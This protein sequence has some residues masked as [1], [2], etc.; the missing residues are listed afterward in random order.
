MTSHTSHLKISVNIKT[1]HENFTQKSNGIQ[2]MREWHVGQTCSGDFN[3]KF[4][5]GKFCMTSC[6]RHK[7]GVTDYYNSRPIYRPVRYTMG[8]ILSS[9]REHK[10]YFKYISQ[11]NCYWSDCMFFLLLS[12]G[13]QVSRFSHY[14]SL[15]CQA[16]FVGHIWKCPTAQC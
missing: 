11:C 1:F 13:V 16:D 9:S 7:K 10:S 15:G 8:C 4:L 12:H 3:L 5:V 6:H 2:M 14:S